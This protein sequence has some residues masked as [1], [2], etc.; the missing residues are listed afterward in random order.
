MHAQ[1]AR[2]PCSAARMRA[3]DWP[4]VS[5]SQAEHTHSKKQTVIAVSQSDRT[6]IRGCMHAILPKTL[7]PPKTHPLAACFVF[8]PQLGFCLYKMEAFVTPTKV[9]PYLTDA[10]KK[11][12]GRSTN[13]VFRS[14]GKIDDC[15][16]AGYYVHNKSLG[17]GGFGKVK[18]ATHLKTNQKVAVKIMNKEKLG[19]CISSDFSVFELINCFP[20]AARHSTREN[21]NRI[22]QSASARQYCQAVASYW[23]WSWD[24]SYP[25]GMISMFCLHSYCFVFA[26]KSIAAEENFLTTWYPRSDS[27]KVKFVL[28]WGICSMC[29]ST[30]TIVDLLIE[31]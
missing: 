14:A 8:N 13:A 5:Q 24:L 18:L 1:R 12:L 4:A 6:E 27:L 31:I 16:D 28:S 11:R 10:Q 25:R 9:N 19:V 22:T 30:S 15:L 2:L 23:N 21:R 26:S 3:A 20:F 29:C 17:E 7:Y